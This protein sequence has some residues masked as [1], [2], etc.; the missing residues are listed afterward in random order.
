MINGSQLTEWYPKP[1]KNN[2]L[3]TEPLTEG[4]DLTHKLGTL[5]KRTMYGSAF[6]IF[7][8]V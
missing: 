1:K 7:L 3:N 4:Q 6:T 8:Y 5:E 2:I